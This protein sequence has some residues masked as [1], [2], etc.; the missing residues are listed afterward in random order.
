LST[1]ATTPHADTA[2]H[3]SQNCTPCQTHKTTPLTG[4][5]N[6]ACPTC[7]ARLVAKT[8]P[9]RMQAKAM[10]AAIARHPGSPPRAAVLA[11]VAG[12]VRG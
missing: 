11:L 10:L 2:A 3:K 1:T 6:M 12:V 9:D 5:V 4:R 8:H 7:C